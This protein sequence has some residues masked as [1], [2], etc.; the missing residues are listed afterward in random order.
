[1][2]DEATNGCVVEVESVVNEVLV[3]LLLML[4]ETFVGNELKLEGLIIEELVL[5]ANDVF[6]EDEIVLEDCFGAG[7]ADECAL[8]LEEV[9]GEK[10]FELEVSPSQKVE[11]KEIVG[12]DFFGERD[13]L[14]C[15]ILGAVAVGVAKL[16]IIEFAQEHY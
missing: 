12:I 16:P 6:D 7:L 14:D 3:G 10:E 5:V 9:C 1:M 2:D 13:E 11:V 4:G 8:L 15:E